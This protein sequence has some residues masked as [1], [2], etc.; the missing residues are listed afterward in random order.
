MSAV[1][2]TDASSDAER[3]TGQTQR[4]V[5][6]FN[7]VLWTGLMASTPCAVAGPQRGNAIGDWS[8]RSATEKAREAM[9][10]TRRL[11]GAAWRPA[12]HPG[13][14][15]LRS[16]RQRHRDTEADVVDDVG[17]LAAIGGA[18]DHRIAAP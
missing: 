16:G 6:R 9:W 17:V 18:E 13:E 2:G 7:G 11:N 10:G 14:Q 3:N 4:E 1:F 12:A 15:R 8:R 5:R